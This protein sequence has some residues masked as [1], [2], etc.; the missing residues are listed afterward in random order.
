[1]AA[2][3]AG[4]AHNDVKASNV[5]LDDGR[6]VPHR[7]RDRRGPRRIGRRRRRRRHRRPR[8]DG[9]GA[10]R[11]DAS[12]AGAAGGG[13]QPTIPGIPSLV[14]RIPRSAG[15][16]RRR[17]A[18]GRGR[19]LSKRRR[20]LLAWRA[21]TGDPRRP[22]QPDLI[23]RRDAFA[24]ANSPAVAASGKNP[25]RACGRST[26]PTRPSSEV[27]TASSENLPRRSRR[28]RSWRSS[29][30][31]IGEVLGRARRS[32]TTA[33]RRWR[34]RRDDGARRR[35]ARRARD[36]SSEVT[37]LLTRRR[38]RPACGRRSTTWRE[39]RGGS[40]WS[41]ISSRSAGPGP[42]GPKREAFRGRFRR[43]RRRV[44]RHPIHH[45]GAGRSA[46][47]PAGR[48]IDRHARR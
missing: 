8:P 16:P 35:T 19:G 29:E 36:G 23:R 45:D 7:L 27:E 5:L 41:W 15:R 42:D 21:A 38:G 34:R 11:R 2:H 20:V 10:A 24:P 17:A 32:R 48:P 12:G 6:G 37:T 18:P 44:G 46:R 9:V 28:D 47:P 1:M 4:V 33:A 22:A 26:R 39:G 3:A 13:I 40:S 30:H 25:Y 43:G 14:G 31:R